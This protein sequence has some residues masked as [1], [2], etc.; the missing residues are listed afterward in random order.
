M[1]AGLA[2]ALHHLIIKPPLFALA[3]RWGGSLDD[4]T[5]AAKSAPVVAVLF[6]LFALSII[7][8]PPLP[9]FWTKLLVLTGL[10]QEGQA[11]HMLAFAAILVVTVVEANY[12]FRLAVRLYQKVERPPEAHAPLDIGAA[13][14]MGAVV[15]GV[16]LMIDPVGDKL[17]DVA[18]EASNVS[19]YVSTVLPVD[20][21]N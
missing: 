15:I 8:V 2:V 13:S 18:R 20:R 5:G 7:G 4:L 17:R 12:L 19:T 1:L 14:L 11:L 10:A 21:K 3:V 9:G 16:T 6:V